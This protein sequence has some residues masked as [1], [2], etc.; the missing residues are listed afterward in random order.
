MEN[1][2]TFLGL[3]ATHR[4]GQKITQ[5]VKNYDEV[6]KSKKHFPLW[7][8][9][10]KDGVYALIVKR[11]D[12]KVKLFSRTGKPYTNTD[13]LHFRMRHLPP[14]VYIAELCID[15]CSLETLSG[16]VNPNRVKPCSEDQESLK[17][18]MYPAF[19]DMIPLSDFMQGHCFISYNYRY[20]NLQEVLPSYLTLL[21]IQCLTC[22]TE[23]DEHVTECIAAGEEGAVFKQ[24]DEGWVAGHKGY[25]QMKKVRGVDYDLTCIGWEEG[26]GKYKGKIANL[27]FRWKGDKIIKAMLGKGWTHEDAEEMYQN[28]TYQDMVDMPGYMHK[29]SPV[30]QIFQVY[31]LQESSKGKLRLPKV[32]ERRHDKEVSDI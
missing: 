13:H 9:I 3:P 17:C 27:L 21:D 24:P 30:D 2:F 14:A 28:C 25:R 31:A 23:L 8:Q 10:K 15:E 4:T 16:I 7:V 19:H 1:V 18:L 22:E 29:D 6:P 11:G 12:D 5:H 20:Q 32:G 26:T